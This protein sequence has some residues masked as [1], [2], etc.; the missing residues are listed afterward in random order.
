VSGPRIGL[1]GDLARLPDL[2]D[3]LPAVPP[4]HDFLDVR[5]F[6]PSRDNVEKAVAADALVFRQ[7]Q[8]EPLDAVGVAALADDADRAIAVK[9]PRR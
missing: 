9:R 2:A 1:L 8:L 4:L 3:D 7:A 6:V 5:K